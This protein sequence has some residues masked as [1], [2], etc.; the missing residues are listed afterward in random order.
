MRCLASL[1][2]AAV[3][4]LSCP[5]QTDD[6]SLRPDVAGS[7]DQAGG[8]AALIEQPPEQT[9]PPSSAVQDEGERLDVAAS[10][11]L[12]NR[13]FFLRHANL[14]WLIGHHGISEP[15][16]ATVSRAGFLPFWPRDPYSGDL[17]QILRE[18]D[19]TGSQIAYYPAGDVGWDYH[20]V[21][22]RYISDPAAQSV[23]MESSNGVTRDYL[24]STRRMA[25][26][27]EPAEDSSNDDWDLM[28]WTF[29]QMSKWPVEPFVKANN[30]VP[31]TLS[32]VL[33]H[34]YVLNQD[35]LDRAR[36]LID[37]GAYAAFEFGAIPEM[38]MLYFDYEMRGAPARPIAVKYRITGSGYDL[39]DPRRV[40]T[41]GL[42][43]VPETA[44]RVVILSIDMIL[45]DPDTWL[46]AEDRAPLSAFYHP[47]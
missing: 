25:T 19:P 26:D 11:A 15:D 9:Q 4:V 29:I 3:V 22:M 40:I 44:N 37:S 17:I 46:P 23:L 1:C 27:S 8:A 30:R 39:S 21:P 45:A 24:E 47:D 20:I 16:L 18:R 31:V 2:L 14:C 32:E 7:N 33:D 12:Q 42:E 43:V 41:Y 36:E 6:R 35:F 13:I 5:T 34:H 38:D 28:I 10:T